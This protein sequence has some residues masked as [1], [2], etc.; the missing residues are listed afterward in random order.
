MRSKLNLLSNELVALIPCEILVQQLNHSW[1]MEENY[2]SKTVPTIS[3]VIKKSLD[4]LFP[5]FRV[6]L[7]NP[8]LGTSFS[9]QSHNDRERSSPSCQ[10]I[11]DSGAS[12][13]ISDNQNLFSNLIHSTT[14]TGVT[15]ANGSRTTVKGIG[16]MQFLS[17]ISL[18]SVLFAPECSFNLISVSKLT[19]HLNC[20]VNFLAD[21][22]VVQDRRTGKTIGTGY[23]SQGLYH[24]SKSPPPVNFTSAASTDLLHNRF[25]HPSLAKLQKLI[26]SLSTLSSL[27]FAKIASVQLL[28]SLAAMHH[29]PLYQLDIKNAFLHG[30]LIEEVYMEQPPGSIAQGE[31]YLV[32][33]LNRSLYGLKQSLRAWLGR[34]SSVVQQFEMSQSK[35]DHSVY[36][37]HNGPSKNIFL[38]VYVDDII[39]EE[40]SQLKQHLFSHFQTRDLEKLKYFLGIEIGQVP[41]LINAPLWVLYHDWR[42]FNF[43]EKKGHW[44]PADQSPSSL[45]GIQGYRVFIAIAIILGDGLY[46]I[47]KVLGRTLYDTNQTFLK[48][49]IPTWVAIVGYVTI[50]IVSTITLPHIFHQLKWYYSIVIYI[51][52][53]VL[54]FCNAYGYGLTDW[55]LASTYGKLAIFTIRAWAGAVHGDVLASLATCGV[56][57]NIVSTAS[58]LT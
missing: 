48:D 52:A 55:S 53:P 51:F 11:L 41:H 13:H 31:S 12:D 21:S 37:R 2:R 29:W 7:T 1:S 25:G 6:L 3:A 42:Q 8:F 50:A 9:C 43:L 16:D 32:C 27:E 35:A 10:W 14:Y 24:M 39:P 30:E 49:Q 36:Y 56:M 54:S 19:K 47:I 26:P 4:L 45:H 38:V 15:L 5:L 34:S 44:Y 40:I 58:D 17:S 46:N 22:V 18:N 23:E 57:M 28:I 20:G 33:H